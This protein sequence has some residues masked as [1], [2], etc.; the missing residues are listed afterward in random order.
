MTLS[1]LT[2]QVFSQFLAKLSIITVYFEIDTPH[3]CQTPISLEL[4]D[5][6]R[7]FLFALSTE[8]FRH[9][10][11]ITVTIIKEYVSDEFPNS[12]VQILT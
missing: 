3:E 7:F 2:A 4:V 5:R 9:S 12:K 11:I 8:Q 6:M 1:R 10:T